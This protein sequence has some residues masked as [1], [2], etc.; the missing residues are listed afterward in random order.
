MHV[1]TL[2]RHDKIFSLSHC[3]EI[4]CMKHFE[5]SQTAIMPKCPEL[6]K[7]MIKAW[8]LA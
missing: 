1:H 4:H 6:F 8:N 3:I 2:S 7:L 5:N